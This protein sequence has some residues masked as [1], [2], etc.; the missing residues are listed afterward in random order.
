M[1]AAENTTDLAVIASLHRAG[2]AEAERAELPDVEAI[3]SEWRKHPDA[4]FLVLRE[5]EPAV[6]L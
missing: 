4:R 5:V 3:V 2:L 1:T 6:S